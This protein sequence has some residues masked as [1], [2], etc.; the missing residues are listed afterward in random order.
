MEPTAPRLAAGIAG[1]FRFHVV[2][3]CLPRI[4][5]S[6]A[7]LDDEQLWRR[8]GA[9][10]NSIGHLC[11]HLEG[12]VR[13]WILAGIGGDPDARDRPAEFASGPQPRDQVLDRLDATARAAADLIDTLDAS[14]LL[15]VRTFQG[16]F[17][18]DVLGAVL[19]VLEHF[20]GHA[21]QIYAFTKA[22]TDEDL[23]FWDL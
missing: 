23:G 15:E 10:G 3:E 17:D 8:Q 20:A 14:T 18:R 5:Q 13:Q 12:N 11:L 9:Q 7:R 4:R 16:R 19:H 21:Y 22:M 1:A 6:V 2:E